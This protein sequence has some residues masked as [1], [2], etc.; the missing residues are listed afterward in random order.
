M[1]EKDKNVE[2]GVVERGTVGSFF[3]FKYVRDVVREE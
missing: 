3:F 1:C 2:S